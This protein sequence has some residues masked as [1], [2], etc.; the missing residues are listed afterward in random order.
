MRFRLPYELVTGVWFS[1][2]TSSILQLSERFRWQIGLTG[3]SFARAHKSVWFHSMSLRKSFM[4]WWASGRR[5]CQHNISLGHPR[6]SSILPNMILFKPWSK[7][8]VLHGVLKVFAQFEKSLK[9]STV[10]LLGLMLVQDLKIDF[11]D[12]LYK[13]NKPKTCEVKFKNSAV[14]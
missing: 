5:C 1:L 14:L 12:E 3:V 4:L 2:E 7:I 10:L 9:N 13:W 6:I 8:S 11:F